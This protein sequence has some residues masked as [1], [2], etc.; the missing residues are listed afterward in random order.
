MLDSYCLILQIR[1]VSFVFCREG[2][3]AV[4]MIDK[5]KNSVSSNDKASDPMDELIHLVSRR[6]EGA[7]GSFPT[8]IEG[9]IF[10]RYSSKTQPT[11]YVQETAICCVLQGH[12]IVMLGKKSHSIDPAN[13]LVASVELPVSGYISDASPKK[14]YLGIILVINPKDLAALIIEAGRQPSRRDDKDC[15][16]L[17]ITK[18][19]DS[20]ADPLIRL[21]KLLDAPAEI[22]IMAP[23]IKR[24]INFRL[25][26]TE[27]F[28]LLSQTAVG[29]G[30]LGRVSHAISWI[31]ENIA[32]PLRIE[33]I[34]KQVHMSPSSL[35]H[36]FKEVTSVSP[37][38]FQ[39]NLRLQKARQLLLMNNT[40]AEKVAYLVGYESPSQFNREYARLFGE[41]PLRDANKMKLSQKEGSQQS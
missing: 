13:C 21:V 5:A 30:K 37:L 35:H 6:T 29:D 17:A 23:M 25:L 8:P 33:D 20:L 32:Q 27:Q 15:Q 14:P 31:K 19:T 11:C 3:Y 7:E 28:D 4:R 41:P 9:L 34:A 24:E 26:Q 12:K 39:K 36:H 2:G 10:S 38:Q 16:A 18:I 22:P 40:S 1:A